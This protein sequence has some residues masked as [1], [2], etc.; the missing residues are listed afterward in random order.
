[1]T[2]CIGIKPGWWAT[3]YLDMAC[4]TARVARM[5][6]SIL[7]LKIMLVGKAEKRQKIVLFACYAIILQEVFCEAKKGPNIFLAGALPQT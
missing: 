1:M 3:Q 2:L 4:S 6:V 5:N 7:S